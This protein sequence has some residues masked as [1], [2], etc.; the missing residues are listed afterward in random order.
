M[1]KRTF[2][3]VTLV[4]VFVAGLLHF[5]VWRDSAVELLQYSR[6]ALAERELWRLLS[7][8]LVHFS[9]THLASDSAAFCLL[10]MLVERQEGRATF[11]V[12]LSVLALGTS[13]ALWFCVPDLAYYGGISALNYGLLTW[14]CL[15]QRKRLGASWRWM[16]VLLPLLLL[17]HVGWQYHSETSLLVT[18]L[19]RFVRVAWQAHLA[20]VLL[21]CVCTGIRGAARCWAFTRAS[22]AMRETASLPRDASPVRC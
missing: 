21:A 16:P 20:A 15:T 1:N 10:G 3:L 4:L 8:H 5:T 12:L 19:P 9:W 17:A 18:A 13:I 2:P 14:M 7:G 22:A 11:A 6:S